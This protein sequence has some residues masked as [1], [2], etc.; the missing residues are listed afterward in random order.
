MSEVCEHSVGY[1]TE[2]YSSDEGEGST[3]DLAADFADDETYAVFIAHHEMAKDI[4]SQLSRV[5]FGLQMH[6]RSMK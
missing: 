2:H 6:I 1:L 3:Y 4:R 5:A